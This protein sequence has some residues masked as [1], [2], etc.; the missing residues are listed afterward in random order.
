MRPRVGPS[1][2]AV[3]ASLLLVVLI[4][5]GCG[6]SPPTPSASPA[7]T[8][9]L[10]RATLEALRF[11]EEF[12]LRADLEFITAVAANPLAVMDFGVPLLP[13]EVREIERRGA[14][15]ERIVPVV[16]SYAA[17]FPAEF[18]G[19]YIDQSSGGRVTVLW[20][21]HLAEHDAA[22]REKLFGIGPVVLRQVR[23]S[24]VDLGNLQNRIGEDQVWFKSI[25]AMLQ[26]VGLDTIGNRIDVSISSK[27]AGAKGLMINRYAVPP[28]MIEVLSDGT[29][30][31]FIPVA[32]I[33][34]RV[35]TANGKPPGQNGYD[36]TTRSQG[37]GSCGGDIDGVGHGVTPDGTFEIPCQAG[38]WTIAIR[39][40]VPG[41]DWVELGHAE[42][43][44]PPGGIV[45]MLIKLDPA[46]P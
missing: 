41:V 32:T 22:L 36:I 46:V 19:V 18:G 2:Y 45:E 1:A 31:A 3:A 43:V 27:N 17:G 40:L 26:S 11:R 9:E 23:Y 25:Q 30:A 14:D 21:D 6:S 5:A 37:P 24:E 34:G 10:D 29:G 15:A 16:Q 7:V 38:T 39:D 13:E 28:D 42:V 35:V 33:K 8:P 12:G 20:T 4:L 44:V